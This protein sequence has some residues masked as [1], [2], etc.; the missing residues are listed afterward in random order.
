MA[1]RLHGWQR[2]WIVL[3]IL[4]LLVVISFDFFIW[5][6]SKSI[7]KH[8]LNEVDKLISKSKGGE[9]RYELTDLV[10]SLNRD[11][12]DIV[13]E[14]NRQGVF[15]NGA[16]SREEANLMAHENWAKLA[17]LLIARHK[18]DIDFTEIESQY[19]RDLRKVS[20]ERKRIVLFS[21]LFWVASV[22]GV[23]LFGLSIRWII[24]GFKEKSNT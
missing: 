23:Y 9:K 15:E 5:P 10:E 1:F 22:V 21:L 7:E 6:E 17:D 14:F 8:R 3:S 13:E 24:R 16:W 20:D 12:V 11:G 18:G 2:L 4:Y 19:K